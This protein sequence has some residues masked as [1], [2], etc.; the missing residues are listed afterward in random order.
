M[1]WPYSRQL[2]WLFFTSEQVVFL[3]A[4]NQ[5]KRYILFFE[6][7]FWIFQNIFFS[8]N[9]AKLVIIHRG[10]H[11]K[12]G[13]FIIFDFKNYSKYQN[14]PLSQKKIP[15]QNLPSPKGWPTI[16]LQNR[17][18]QGGWSALFYSLIVA[19]PFV[20]GKFWGHIFLWL[21]GTFWYLE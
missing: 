20:L 12:H 5:K 15:F 10:D 17:A 18:H 16:K 3:G 19:K 2:L 1:D 8:P 7:R 9:L 11:Y 13:K 14:V 4:F 21:M 6:I